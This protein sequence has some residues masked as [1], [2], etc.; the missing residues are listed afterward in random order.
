[1][2]GA[3][4]TTIRTTPYPQAPT[5]TAPTDVGKM[6]AQRAFFAAL[7]GKTETP[8]EPPAPTSASPAPT[9][10]TAPASSF[11]RIPRPGSLIDIRV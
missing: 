6:A 4:V 11:D 2:F 8:T 5:P 3:T 10:R 9:S 1:M 7:T